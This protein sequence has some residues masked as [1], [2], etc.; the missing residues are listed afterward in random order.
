MNYSSGRARGIENTP[1][2]S[3]FMIGVAV[4]MDNGSAFS[5][6]PLTLGGVPE[7]VYIETSMLTPAPATIRIKFLDLQ[8]NEMPSSSNLVFIRREEDTA[9]LNLNYGASSIPIGNSRE[10]G[11]IVFNCF[12]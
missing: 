2:S 6:N 10:Y 12:M 1:K 4:R 9:K 7:E 8:E 3:I 11:S 5:T